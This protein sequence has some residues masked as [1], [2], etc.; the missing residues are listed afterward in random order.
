MDE[1][2]FQR[3]MSY[4]KLTG[5]D[6]ATGYQRGLRRHYHGEIFG[7]TEEHEKYMSLGTNGDYRADLGDGYRAGFSGQAFNTTEGRA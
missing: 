5:G 1:K 2:T 6:F 7:T 4:A 3:N